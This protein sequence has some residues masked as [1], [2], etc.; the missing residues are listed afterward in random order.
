MAQE[1]MQEKTEQAT[2]KKLRD[3]REKGDVAK[4]AEI[5]SVFIVLCGISALYYFSGFMYSKMTAIMRD[6]FYLSRIPDVNSKYCIDLLNTY[7]FKYVLI[8]MPVMLTVF[9]IALAS[10]IYMVG[11]QINFTALE[12]KFNKLNPIQGLANKLSLSSVVEL[13]KSIA[14]LIVISLLTWFA[15]KS[16]IHYIYTLYDNTIGQILLFICRLVHKIFLWVIVPMVVLAVFDYMYQLWQFADKMKMTKQEVK[17]EFKQTEGD[18]KVKSRIRAIQY[19]AARKRMMAE[20]PHADVV[21]TN[22]THL[23]VAIKYDPSKMPAP[24]VTAKGAGEVAAKIRELARK[25]NVPVIENKQLA[26]N[27]YKHVDIGREIP[28]TLYMAVAELLA[29]VYKIKGR[30]L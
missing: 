18:P 4:S 30:N 28:G 22:P 20:V 17:D 12:F 15:V 14:K 27:L 23:A 7:F 10:N 19:E 29:H 13:I 6:C 2:G 8:V 26:R 3:A 25:S 24:L 9:L 5:P 1:S 11:F 21:V 16:E